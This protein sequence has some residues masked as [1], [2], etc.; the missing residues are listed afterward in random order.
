MRIGE[1][2]ERSGV[3]VPTIK[4]YVREGL[5]PA[6][7]RTKT[8]QAR[9]SEAHLRR[10]GL[11]RALIEIGGLSVRAA[12]RVLTLLDE[13]RAAPLWAM[14]KAQY[15]LLA[16][17]GPPEHPE[18]HPEVDALLE[19]HGW[20][21]GPNNPARAALAQ[22]WARMRELG[23]VDVSARL[24]EFARAAAE[25][26]ARDVEAVFGGGSMDEVAEQVVLWTVLGDRA[27][28]ALRRL[29]QEDAARRAG[30]TWRFHDQ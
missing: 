11:V 14:G 20:S 26:A 25:L 23:L 29:A 4:Y 6:G 24:D 19:R 2:S 30:H 7:E 28:L 21:V 27:L 18:E 15:A 13:P 22:T 17:D 9:Y 5:L 16:P 1:L 12:T 8:N 10:L 3:P